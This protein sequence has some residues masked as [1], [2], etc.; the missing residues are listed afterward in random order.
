MKRLLVLD[1]AAKYWRGVSGVY[2]GLARLRRPVL[3][4][5]PSS[6]SRHALRGKC[7]DIELASSC[8]IRSEEKRGWDGWLLQGILR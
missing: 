3:F 1:C 5:L 4:F 8:M 6:I 2:D 7:T